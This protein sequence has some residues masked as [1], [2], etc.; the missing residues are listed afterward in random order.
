MIYEHQV[1]YS[2]ASILTIQ[3]TKV[4]AY[5]YIYISLG[6]FFFFENICRNLEK[7]SPKKKEQK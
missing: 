5:L 1:I 4:C 7:V 6:L 2:T 3:T